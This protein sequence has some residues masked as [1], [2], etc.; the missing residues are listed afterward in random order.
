MLKQIL[1]AGLVPNITGSPGI[2]KSSLVVKLAKEYGFEL[3]ILKL[4]QISELDLAGLPNIN[5]ENNS[6]TYAPPALFPL[7]GR[8]PEPEK[9]VIIFLDEFNQASR[10]VQAAAYGLILDKEVGEYTL[11]D[12]VYLVCAGNLATDGAIVNEIGTALQSRV[13]HMELL[14]E[15]DRWLAWAVKNNIDHRIIAYINYKNESITNFDPDHTDKTFTCP[16]TLEFASKILTANPEIKMDA[17]AVPIL[18]GCIGEATA[19]DIVV[20]SE[21]YDK[22]PTWEQI[23]DNPSSAKVPENEASALYAVVS[24]VASKITKENTEDLMVYIERL[25]L[26][27]Q[28]VFFQHASGK[29]HNFTSIPV[30][31]AWINEHAAQ[32]A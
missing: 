20:Y 22:I 1:N 18:A 23:K 17:T 13:I 10:N 19:R 6:F 11:H 8:D 4:S 24:L 26:E 30:I 31:N 9:P 16:R 21:V 3:K 25:P 15:A 32:I 7:K 5:K 2:A 29:V 27:Y 12:N 14:P 28:L